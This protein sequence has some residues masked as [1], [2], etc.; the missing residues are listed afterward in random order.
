MFYKKEKK[1]L[2]GPHCWLPVDTVNNFSIAL[3]LNRNS[4]KLFLLAEY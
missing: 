3:Q 1:F 4:N 2:P